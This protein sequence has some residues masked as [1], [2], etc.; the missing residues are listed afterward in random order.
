MSLFSACVVPMVLVC[1]LVSSL[2]TGT[3]QKAIEEEIGGS[4][5][6]VAT[7]VRETYANLYE[8]EY[9]M[10]K[11]GRVRKGEKEISGDYQLVDAIKE[12]TG[13]DVSFLFGDMRLITTVRKDTGAR[14]NGTKVDKEL[15]E[16]IQ[17]GVPFF[18]KDLEIQNRKCYVYYL[19]LVNADGTVLGAI[20]AI[21]ESASI[22][23]V[24]NGQTVVITLTAVVLLVAVGV[25]AIFISSKM[26][27]RMSRIG[28]FLE[29]LI[30]G[31]LDFEPHQRSLK[32]N[33]ELGDIY[34]N[35]AKVQDTFK[36][37]VEKINVSYTELLEAARKLSEMA[38]NT[39][40]YASDV[41]VAVEEIAEG[42]RSQAD[43]TQQANDNMSQMSEQIGLIA[44]EVDAM[45][46][47]AD[48][49]ATQEQESERIIEQLAKSGEQ[50]KE[51]VAKVAE[52]IETMNR[53]VSS[54]KDA[55]TMIQSIADETDLLSL[56]ASIEAARAGAAG[57][58]FAVVAE[59]ISKLSL[60]S[61]QSSRDIEHIL[62]EISRISDTL[63]SVMVDVSGSMDQQQERL[64]ETKV[65]YRAVSVGVEKSL[66]NIRSI[67]GKIGVL[68]ESGNSINDTIESLAAIAQQNAASASNTMETT[69]Y[70]SETMKQVRCSANE[71]LQ[72]A[73]VLRETLQVFRV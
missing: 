14:V 37:M 6:I 69:E 63:V 72:L 66:E 19:P 11:S 46:V 3:L 24:I 39:T 73:D 41:S 53:A 5:Q 55:V 54:I 1:I 44:Q 9:S 60:S 57:R 56:N 48:G 16:K 49:M 10:D 33:D 71:L 29:S 12:G 8:G 40:E 23:Q 59:Q 68:N 7:S 31:R 15:Y 58:G 25:I 51:S 70:M 36:D 20:E 64:E 50:T 30:S 17:Q 67:K 27:K 2:S 47:Y 18:Q 65:T 4:L 35:C 61:A 28:V 52:Q 43:S 22:Q 45:A 21:R 34:R 26:V 38:E 13:Y 62:G 32:R 42:A